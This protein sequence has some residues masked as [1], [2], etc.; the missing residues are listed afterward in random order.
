MNVTNVL[1]TN[2]VLVFIRD[3]IQK[4]NLTY[5]VNVVNSLATKVVFTLIREYIQ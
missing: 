1:P 3:L 4:R 2:A 5:V